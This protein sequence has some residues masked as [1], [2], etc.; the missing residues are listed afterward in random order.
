MSSYG[1]MQG[2]SQLLSDVQMESLWECVGGRRAAIQARLSA[3]QNAKPSSE[4]VEDECL[5][6]W[7]NTKT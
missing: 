2:D 5:A 6:A 7:L 1:G 3:L 4:L